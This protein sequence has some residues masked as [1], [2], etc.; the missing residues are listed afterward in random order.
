[1]IYH[2]NRLLMDKFTDSPWDST[3]STGK[4]TPDKQ[5]VDRKHMGRLDNKLMDRILL[6]RLLMDKV[7]YRDRPMDRA[8]QDNK[9]MHKIPQDTKLTKS[10]PRLFSKIT[11]AVKEQRL[12][13]AMKSNIVSLT[14]T[15]NRV[16]RKAMDN[17]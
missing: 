13:Q 5:K 16:H 14:A 9:L 8:A 10:K 3:K 7:M 12:M 11:L 6:D 2:S 15:T 17:S 4:E 1:M